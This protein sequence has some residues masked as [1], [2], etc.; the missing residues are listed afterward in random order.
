LQTNAVLVR[1]PRKTPDLSRSSRA[2]RLS[3]TNFATQ[4]RL[5][6]IDY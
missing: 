5:L 3:C 2:I 1:T 6:P 4:T